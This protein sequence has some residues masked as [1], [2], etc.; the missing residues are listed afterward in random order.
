MLFIRDIIANNV[1]RNIIG[2]LIVSAII[3]FYYFMMTG[4]DA[5]Y[6]EL[7]AISTNIDKWLAAS[8]FMEG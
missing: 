1:N 2:I 5:D 6:S 4:F 8:Y 3:L 7:S